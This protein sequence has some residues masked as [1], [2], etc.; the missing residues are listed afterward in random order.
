MRNRTYKKFLTALLSFACLAMSA[1][2]CGEENPAVRPEDVELMDPVGV[3]ESYE[4][5]ARRNLYDAKVYS[6]LVC[7]YTEEYSLDNSMVFSD[8]GALPG[9][10][11]RKGETLLRTDTEYADKQIENLEKTIERNRKEHEEYLV[12]TR[13][14]LEKVRGDENFWGG[15]VERWALERPDEETEEYQQWYEENQYYESRYRNAMISRQKLE[16]AL[17]QRTELYQLDADYNQTLLRRLRKDKDN[18]TVLT[19]ISGVAVNMQLMDQGMWIPADYPVAAVADPKRKRI[20]CEYIL[21]EEINRA[22]RVYA[23][24]N[25]IYYEVEYVPAENDSDSYAT[26]RLPE[27]AGDMELGVYV[28]IV[29][30][31]QSRMDV[32]TV[33]KDAVTKEEDDSFVYLL[34][35]GERVYTPV[36]TGMQDGVYVEILSG[37]EEGDKVLTAKDAPTANSTLTLQKGSV[38]HEFSQ[39]GY[40]AYPRQ[41]WI[42]NPVVY[43]TAYFGELMVNINQPVKKGEVLF[44]LRVKADEVELARNEKR[45]QRE[46]ER[47]AQLQ[48]EDPEKNK[49]AIEARQETIAELE[50][51]IGEMKKDFAITQVKAPYDGIVTD[52]S[53]ELWRRSL[54]DGDLLKSNQALVML[55]R[56]DTNY[57]IVEDKNGMLSYGHQANITY[58]GADGTQRTTGGTVVTL[59]KASVS[60]ELFGEGYALIRVSSEDAREMAGSISNGEGWWSRNLY[61]VSVNTRK[62]E[63]VVLVPRKA[64][65]S[66]GSVTYV[67]LKQKDGSVLYQSFVAGGSDNTNYWVAEGLTEGMEVCIE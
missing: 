34:E 15:A 12:E 56:Q 64:V 65:V 19:E 67:K 25:G 23:I 38:S 47:L 31:K 61:D 18:S 62:M 30:V 53:M 32:L 27:G 7:P 14:E 54:Q 59:N 6:G 46:R 35:N 36:R 9:D 20:R 24:V 26:F 52:L 3:G 40:L 55:S 66:Y 28:V 5:A 10:T 51:L 39:K 43:G 41:E 58:S 49:K 1:T 13:E 21:K 42:C 33:P 17:K 44:T 29:V 4:A 11:V 63:N 2:G 45:L 60:E 8:Y 50:K 37:V 57:I 48:K 22:E 16:E